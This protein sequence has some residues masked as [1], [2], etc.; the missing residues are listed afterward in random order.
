MANENVPRGAVD[1]A[2]RDLEQEH[3]RLKQLSAKLLLTSEAADL[4]PLVRELRAALRDHFAHEEHPG[5]LYDRMGACSARF[6][7]QVLTLIDDH[8]RIL[9]TLRM[10]SDSIESRRASADELEVEARGLADRLLA[11]ELREHELAHAAAEKR[12]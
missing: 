9:A 10:L 8:Y 11:H 5:G 12:D 7:D 4:A 2:I 6:R 3:L 1:H